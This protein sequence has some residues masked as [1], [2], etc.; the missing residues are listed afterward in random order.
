MIQRY[1][2]F[3][4]MTVREAEDDIILEGYFA[5]FDSIYELWPGHT[6]SIAKGAFD[7]CLEQDIRALWNHNQDIVLGRTGAGTLTLEADDKG[8]KGAIRINRKDQDAMNA[9]ARVER[10]DCCG[11]S[12]G[13]EIGEESA[14]YREDGTVHWTITRVSKLYE[15]SPCVFP[16]YEETSINARKKEVDDHNR[17]KLEVWRKEMRERLKGGRDGD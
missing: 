9:A 8:L 12:F 11:C 2:P 4:D 5:V 14:D 10:Q 6:E 3:K 1:I 17:R 7:G 13:F 15:V 16:A